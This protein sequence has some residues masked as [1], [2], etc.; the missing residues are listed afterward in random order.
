VVDGNVAVRRHLAGKPAPD[1]FLAAASELGVE[2]ARTA[3]V[4]DAVSGV[5]AARA[6][7]FALVIGVDRGAGADALREHGADVVVRDLSETLDE[8]D[9]DRGRAS[10]EEG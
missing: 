1:M 2:P 5:A 7:A 4:E 9:P 10:D 8:T 3:V 6:G